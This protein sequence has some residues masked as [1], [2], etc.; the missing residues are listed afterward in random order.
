MSV[1]ANSLKVSSCK[2]LG[3]S[4][5]TIHT[6]QLKIQEKRVAFCVQDRSLYLKSV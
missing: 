4:H 1:L 3:L 5:Q 2:I 6:V